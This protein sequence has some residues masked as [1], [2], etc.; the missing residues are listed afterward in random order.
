MAGLVLGALFVFPVVAKQSSEER[1]KEVMFA[2]GATWG[3]LAI[4][5]GVVGLAVW[6]VRFVFFR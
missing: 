2:V 5:A 6:I 1:T 3:N 4:L